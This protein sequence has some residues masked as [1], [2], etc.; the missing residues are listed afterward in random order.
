L[1]AKQLLW[2]PGSALAGS[3]GM[4]SIRC[5][6]RNDVRLLQAH[7]DELLADWTLAAAGN[8]PYKIE[9]LR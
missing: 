7:A 2:I 4:T 9:P 8:T 5:A 6:I 3:P 1:A